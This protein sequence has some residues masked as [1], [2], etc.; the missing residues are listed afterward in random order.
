MSFI[1]T[2]KNRNSVSCR[3][4]IWKWI[5]VVCNH[6][7]VMV[8]WSRKT[9]EKNDFFAFFCK[10]V[11]YGGALFT[12]HIRLALQLALLRR[13]HPKSAIASSQQCTRSAR[14][15]FGGGI[16]E[17]VNTVKT[18]H[19]VFPV[20]G[21]SLA[22]NRITRGQSNSSKYQRRRHIWTVQW[23]LPGGNIVYPHKTCSL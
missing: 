13:S 10:K 15:T 22:S 9:L 8:T 18:G 23:Y 17:C 4:I 14:L 16:P 12:G 19:K 2:A 1:R 3:W 11:R 6:C 20:F 7:T 21:W 5:F